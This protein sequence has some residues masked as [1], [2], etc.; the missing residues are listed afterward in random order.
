MKESRF[1]ARLSDS[2]SVVL[3]AVI[4]QPP[5]PRESLLAANVRKAGS[6][7]ITDLVLPS[8]RTRESSRLLA[9]LTPA[10][11]GYEHKN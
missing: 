9:K 1:Q 4:P 7:L 6:A 2:G 5:S 10:L 8:T 11:K 3:S